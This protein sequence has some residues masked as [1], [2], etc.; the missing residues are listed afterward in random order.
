MFNKDDAFITNQNT[1]IEITYQQFIA[2]CIKT[3]SNFS[4]ENYMSDNKSKKLEVKLSKIYKSSK[5][6][7]VKLKTY[8]ENAKRSI[9]R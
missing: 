1:A 5:A 2:Y 8:L 3:D 4:V 7:E 9:K 6:N